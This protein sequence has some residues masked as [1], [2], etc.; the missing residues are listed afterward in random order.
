MDF[1]FY[2]EKLRNL[3]DKQKKIVLWTIVGLLGVILG[4]F[5]LNSSL[6]RLSEMGQSLE[7][8]KL[9]E[10]QMPSVETPTDQT[11]D[12]KTYINSGYGFEIK[13][14]KDISFREDV[15]DSNSLQVIF[16]DGKNNVFVADAEKTSKMN[17][18]YN[19]VVDKTSA[20]NGVSGKIIKLITASND[21]C[22][23]VIA[24]KGDMTYSFNDDCKIDGALFNKILSTFK[25]TK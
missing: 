5:W 17:I 22:Y 9:P 14:P 15:Y 25:F 16:S 8:I 4:Y 23:S 19:Q 24:E 13:Y 2:L 20:I 6:R 11:A 10:V 3:P 21:E 7:S 1:H 18:N 12:W